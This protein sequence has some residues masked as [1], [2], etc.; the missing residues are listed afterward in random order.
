MWYEKFLKNHGLKKD[1]D[2]PEEWDEFVEEAKVNPA[3]ELVD[4]S[5][6]EDPD[7]S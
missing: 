3:L 4:P 2:P 6:K 7:A 5:R 1:V